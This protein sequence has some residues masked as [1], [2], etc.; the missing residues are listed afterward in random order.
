MS[1]EN[2]ENHFSKLPV[3]LSQLIFSAVD[4]PTLLRSVLHTSKN[5]YATAIATETTGTH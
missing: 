4:L 3:E 2:S 1:Q 5:F